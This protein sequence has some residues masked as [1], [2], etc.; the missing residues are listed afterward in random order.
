MRSLNSSFT[1]SGSEFALWGQLMKFTAIAIIAASTILS[2]SSTSGVF[3]KK[4]PHEQYEEVLDD[5]DLDKTPAGRQWLAVSRNVLQ[6]AV[7]AAIPFRQ[8]GYFPAGRA[9]ALGIQFRAKKGERLL[10]QV[11]KGGKEQIFLYT[12]LFRKNGDDHEHLHAAEK[13]TNE[14]GYEIN[15]TGTYVLRVQPELF[16]SGGYELTITSGP[17]IGF[18]VSGS[19]ARIGS[20]WGADRDGG[21]RS[22]EG[23]DIFAPKRTPAVAAAD[24][25]IT[26]VREGGIGGKT[27]WLRPSGADYT[28]YYAHL[29]EQLVTTGQQVK[30]GETVGLVGNTGNAKNTPSHLHFGIYTHRGPVDPLPFVNPVVK[31]PAAVPK[32]EIYEPLRLV[33]TYKSNAGSVN[34]KANSMVTPL[35]VTAQ[36]YISELPDGRLIDVPF[37][38]VQS[39]KKPLKKSSINSNAPVYEHPQKE[40]RSYSVLKPGTSVS[41]LAYHEEYVYIKT[42]SVEGWIEEGYL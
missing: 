13:N 9:H 38:A 40:Q 39:L 12:D 41:V 15:E 10:F 22:H 30:K 2:C 26:S 35:A 17:S 3:S 36:G 6:Y 31:K 42:G 29:D 14:F 25:H 34:A 23:I 18:P 37:A 32:K 4:T 8:T 28:L 11:K 21:R 7:D 19:K 20:F 16:Q 5:K 1:F 27:V 33:K 24:G